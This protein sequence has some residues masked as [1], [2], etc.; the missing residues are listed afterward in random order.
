MYRVI[1]LVCGSYLNEFTKSIKLILHRDQ[2][3]I[4]LPSYQRMIMGTPMLTLGLYELAN[5]VTTNGE[6]SKLKHVYASSA[7]LSIP[8]KSIYP[9]VSYL[10]CDSLPYTAVAKREMLARLLCQS[11]IYCEKWHF[12]YYA[13]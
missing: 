6:Y 8:M 13:R 9:S 10:D 7:N 1:L 3:K 12:A 4:N 5:D 11:L 2:Y